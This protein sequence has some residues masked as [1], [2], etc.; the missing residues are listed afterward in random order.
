MKDRYL[1]LQALDFIF[2]LIF[3]FGL[4]K[5]YLHRMSFFTERGFHSLECR[6]WGFV[7]NSVS[8]V[9][10]FFLFQK[11]IQTFINQN[12][13]KIHEGWMLS[14]YNLHQISFLF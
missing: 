2:I 11:E 14:P 1:P 7:K 4:N 3:I 10:R 12:Q 9:K 6:D 8:Y 13:R 5:K